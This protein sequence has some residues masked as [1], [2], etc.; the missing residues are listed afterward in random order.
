MKA[1]KSMFIPVKRSLSTWVCDKLFIWLIDNLISFCTTPSEAVP[2]APYKYFGIEFGRDCRC[3]TNFLHDP[4]FSAQCNTTC[5]NNPAQ[6]CGGQNVMNLWLNADYVDVSRAFYSGLK[7]LQL[8][9][10]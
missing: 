2:D 4:I 10:S 8:M 6:L 9:D 1:A 5:L 7:E 3:G